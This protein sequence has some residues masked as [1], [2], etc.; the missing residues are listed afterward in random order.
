LYRVFISV[1]F[2]TVGGTGGNNSG[3]AGAVG[4]DHGQ[5][6]NAINLADAVQPDFAIFLAV[7]S[8]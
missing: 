8:P 2:G 4:V 1:P 6:R 7:I 5:D 3:F